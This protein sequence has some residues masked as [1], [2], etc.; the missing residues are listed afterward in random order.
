M[1]LIQTRNLRTVKKDAASL[2]IILVHFN[3]TEITWECI[4]SLTASGYDNFSIIIVDNSNQ[5]K[6]LEF[7]QFRCTESNIFFQQL[8]KKLGSV[9]FNR[10]IYW[11]QAPEN[12]GYAGG[13][14]LGAEIA[15]LSDPD[16]L[17]LLNNDIFVTPDFLSRFLLAIEP[18]MDRPEFGLA[19]CLIKTWPEKKI[20]YAGG[21]FN[22]VRCM[23]EHRLLMPQSMEIQETGFISGCCML[24]RPGVYQELGGL[25]E[26]FFLYFEDVDLC[27]RT[28]KQG[29][30]LFFVPGTELFH[31][32]GSSTGG[33]EK[34]L[35]VYY[36]SRNRVF[37]MRKHFKD[38]TL[39]QFYTFFLFSRIGKTIKWILLG[40]VNLILSLWKG[41]IEGF[42]KIK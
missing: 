41:V 2:V 29:Y 34:P 33:D 35:S 27:Y 1:H 10:S 11:F 23:G 16:F 4:E 25:D 40:K 42:T 26:S 3:N 36:S 21:R 37:L 18:V 22:R 8:E 24:C 14:N 12:M 6:D 28:I 31:R 15:L 17:L 5:P 7:I 9:N 20:W 13:M 19:S 39:Y 32:V 38:L 30:K